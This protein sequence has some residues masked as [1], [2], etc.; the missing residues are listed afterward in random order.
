MMTG[1][2]GL[3]GL[4]HG[5]A[6]ACSCAMSDDPPE[7][8]FENYEV[9]FYGEIVSVQEPVPLG[10]SG[11]VSSADP[12]QVRIDVLEGFKGAEGGEELEFTTARDGSSC[13]I[14]FEVGEAWLI[15]ANTG[16]LGLCDPTEQMNADDP[17]LDV[18]RA[19]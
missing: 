7:V 18:L 4:T 6:W 12:V 10:C 9:V 15:Y 17:D 11:T 16:R 5:V 2:V 8:L 19:L 1:F 3:F 14:A 13:G